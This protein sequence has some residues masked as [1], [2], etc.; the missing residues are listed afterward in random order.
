MKNYA[1]IFFFPFLLSGCMLEPT[2]LGAL[3]PPT[4]DQN[5]VLP[6]MAIEVLGQWRLIHY[7]TFG[8]STNP[9]LFIM[10]G[11]LSD[12]RA[13]LPLQELQDKYF[14]VMWDQRGNGLSERVTEQELSYSSMV[15]E[16]KV[17][18][19][20][21]SPNR[22]ITLMGHSWSA[23][24]VAKYLAKHPTDVEQA[25]LMEP[26][27]LNYEIME[28][29]NIPL[30]LTSEGYLDMMY[31]S[32]Y[33]TPK[34]YETLDYQM[35][36]IL[37]SGVRDYFCDLNNLPPWPV[38]R[39]GGCALI[40]WEKHLL[41]GSKYDY[42]FTTGLTTFSGEVLIVGS[43]CSPIGYEFQKKYHQPLFQNAQVLRIE[44]SGHRIITEQ[45]ESLING[46][47]NFL[48]Y[49]QKDN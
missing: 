25:I 19:N 37:R 48:K 15:E 29:V 42:D 13:Y 2:D 9:A 3:V 31:S 34:D 12:I 7:R 18:K 44:N 24:F 16:I 11:S 35:L 40:I 20:Y 5:S 14:V 32:K 26:F 4:V 17:L 46:L 45:Y 6:S 39:V 8:D 1:F 41:N 38:W 47:R 36:A 27:G 49:F 22:P 28:K 10:H 30:N 21:F 23:V 33:M 43:S